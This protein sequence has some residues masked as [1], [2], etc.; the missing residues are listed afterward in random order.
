[1]PFAGSPGAVRAFGV[2]PGARGHERDALLEQ[3]RVLHEDEG[4][5]AGDLVVLL[6]PSGGKDEILLA[7]MAPAES[8]EASWKRVTDWMAQSEARPPSHDAILRIPNLHFDLTHSYSEFQEAHFTTPG[9]ESFQVLQAMQS[10]LFRLDEKGALLESEAVMSGGLAMP[11]RKD[12]LV[13]DRPFLL[14]LRGSGRA[15]PYFLLWVAN[16]DLMPKAP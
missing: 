5:P 13:F 9:F 1:M 4:A 7:R 2:T 3:V 10:V 15:E 12:L 8:L 16:P 14:A 11:E 6:L